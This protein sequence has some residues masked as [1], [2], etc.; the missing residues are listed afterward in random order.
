VWTPQLCKKQH[1]TTEGGTEPAVHL[2]EKGCIGHFNWRRNIAIRYGDIPTMFSCGIILKNLKN[3][4]LEWIIFRTQT[5]I[6]TNGG[7]DL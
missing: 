7:L 6:F 5:P 4:W 2:G 3:L 1:S